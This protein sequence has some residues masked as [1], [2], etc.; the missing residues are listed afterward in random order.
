MQS[1]SLKH[2][3]PC[4]GLLSS[5]F[6][7]VASGI[8]WGA[9]LPQGSEAKPE[10]RERFLE[11]MSYPQLLPLAR[12]HRALM[13]VREQ[14][15]REQ[16]LPMALAM[17]KV[18]VPAGYPAALR[19][20]GSEKPKPRTGRGFGILEVSDDYNIKSELVKNCIYATS[21]AKSATRSPLVSP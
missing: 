8:F 3:I 6:A 14:R 15:A 9:L 18:R 21:M 12:Q 13:T 1:A 4:I 5:V 2:V 10:R 19:Q 7:I 11:K 20:A 17:V 16:A